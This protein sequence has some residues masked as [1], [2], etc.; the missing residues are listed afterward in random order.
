MTC[1]WFYQP[2]RWLLRN[3]TLGHSIMH[4]S[5]LDRNRV[6][7]RCSECLRSWSVVADFEPS[8]IYKHRQMVARFKGVANVLTFERRR[9]RA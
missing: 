9:K 6:E 1:S 4:P 8:P 5:R 2:L 7:L 3:P